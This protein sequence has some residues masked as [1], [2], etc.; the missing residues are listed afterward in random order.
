MRRVWSMA[1]WSSQT[2]MLRSASP[3]GETESGFYC[4]YGL[5]AQSLPVAQEGCN[6]DL[7]GGRRILIG[8]RRSGELEAAI[9][10]AKGM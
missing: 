9:R 2:M 3:D 5:A 1:R 4:A 10:Q 7:F 8:S 6:D